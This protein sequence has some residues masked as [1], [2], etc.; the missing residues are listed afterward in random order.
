MDKIPHKIIYQD[1]RGESKTMY[2]EPERNTY[3][4]NEE[5]PN[6]HKKGSRFVIILL[7]MLLVAAIAGGLLALSMMNKWK[8]E[9]KNELREELGALAETVEAAESEE[10]EK[11]AKAPP[12]E[13]GN[14]YSASEIYDM[15]CRQV[16]GISVEGQGTNFMGM[17]VPV[18]IS[19][20]GFIIS[21]D[22]HIMTNYHV[23]EEAQRNGYRLTACLHSGEI[24]EAAVVGYDRPNDIAV[25][26]IEAGGL[27]AVKTGDS[28]SLLVGQ[29]IYA[30][31]NPL[32]ELAYTMTT[33]TVSAL[34]RV[35]QTRQSSGMNVFQI[36]AAVNQGNSG[37]P[38]YDQEG[39]VV[40]VVAAKY[41]ETGVEG[42]GFAIPINKAM[43][44]AEQIMTQGYVSGTPYLGISVRPVSPMIADYFRMTLG[45]YVTRV[46]ES[47]QAY[48]K[49]IREGDIV[50]HFNG[51]QLY[52]AEQLERLLEGCR[53][54]DEVTIIFWRLGKGF[55]VS[56]NLDER[57][58]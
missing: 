37:G 22:G 55:E 29:K 50:T 52:S 43:E 32:G 9:I 30:V 3:Y 12:L 10:L 14:F 35:I 34:N 19:G 33:G 28:D 18:A 40:G 49:G 23:I 27:D 20:S 8:D 46:D 48:L 15:A 17:P 42:L 51:E 57:R 11:S 6:A 58:E 44:L 31:G 5:K 39:A 53:A 1:N 41:L 4:K 54:G 7:S 21:S 16:V 2:D 36:D 56:F 47:S 25:I 24:Y 13:V 45:L 26:K 38:V